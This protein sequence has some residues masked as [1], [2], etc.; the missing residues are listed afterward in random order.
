MDMGDSLDD[1]EEGCYAAD[2]ED[3]RLV[4]V[5]SASRSKRLKQAAVG[6]SAAFAAF[7]GFHISSPRNSN[8]RACYASHSAHFT[9]FGS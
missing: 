3:R 5:P 2:P 7:G 4:A 8:P 9:T 6:I 1:H